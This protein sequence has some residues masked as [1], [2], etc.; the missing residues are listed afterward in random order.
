[1]AT[2]SEAKAEDIRLPNGQDSQP[3]EGVRPMTKNRL[4]CQCRGEEIGLI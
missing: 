3:H 4:Y 1:M 2:N